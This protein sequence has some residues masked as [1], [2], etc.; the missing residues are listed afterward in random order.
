M[1]H[2]VRRPAWGV[3]DLDTV[4]GAIFVQEQWRYEWLLG[5]GA[6]AWTLSERRRFHHTADAHI[7]GNW[8]NRV[9]IRATGT[10]AL[11]SL[12]HDLQVSF[13]IRWVLSG[14]QWRVFVTKLAPGVASPRSYVSFATREIHLDTL[15]VVPHAVGNDAGQSRPRFFT[16]PH[17]FGHTLPNASGSGTPVDDEYNSGH[18]HLGDTDSLMNIGHR[19]RARHVQAVV[20]ELNTMLSNCH[21]EVAP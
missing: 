6:T 1:G 9:R 15:D 2:V 19:I 5:A 18:A 20:D 12:G 21:F 11:A 8:S 16:I 4:T 14:G 3:V 7:W 13:D 17:E 10:H